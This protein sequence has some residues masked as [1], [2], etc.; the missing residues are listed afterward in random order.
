MLLTVSQTRRWV[1]IT[2]FV[3]FFLYVGLC[4]VFLSAQRSFLYFPT[5]IRPAHAAAISLVVPD[6]TLRISTR[7][8][9]GTQALIYFGGNA[10]DVSYSLPAFASAFPDRAIYM[11][12]YRGYS[13]SSGRPSEAALHRDAKTLFAMVHSKHPDTMVVGRSLGSGIAIRLAAAEPVSQLVLITPFDSILTLAQRAAPFLPISLLMRDTYQSW[14]SA[15]L[16]TAPTLII[17][18]SHDEL[19]PT[20]SVQKLM[21]AFPPGVVSLRVLPDTDH[22]S[23]SDSPDFMEA[24]KAAQ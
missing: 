24:I 17:A 6:A 2:L 3:L 1:F 9:D 16:V 18:A 4:L 15:P 12:H 22:N 21:R 19:I 23:V 8:H 10:E 13:G 11:L 14:R 20:E 7:P 5:P